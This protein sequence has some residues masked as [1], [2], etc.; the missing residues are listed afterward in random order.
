ML[1]WDDLRFFM[2]LARGGSLSEA[3]RR[4]RADHSTVG[5]RITSL[6]QALDV[7][8]FDR[9]PRGYVLTVEGE[10]LLQRV[11]ALED[12]IA[13][14]ERLAGGGGRIEGRVRISAPP[15]FASHWLVPRLRPLFT[16]YPGIVLDVVGE[17]S[18]ASLARREADLAIRLSRPDGDAL[19]ARRLGA[20]KYGLYGARSYIEATPNDARVF[21]GYDEELQGSPQ[22]KWLES[23]AGGRSSAMLT[24]DLASLL[25]GAR[26]GLGLAALPHAITGDYPELALLT[27]GPAATR[28]LWLVVHPD[29]RR[30]QRVR[31]VMDHLVEIAAPLR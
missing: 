13:S 8:L 6:E 21:L 17:S 27:E 10:R 16:A 11:P 25:A 5:R 3:A 15:A 26:A 22:Q 31:V 19:I 14:I 28:E 12:A 18:E 9:L 2:A 20:L 24:N 30:S 23:V 4:L 1:N 7:K 29:L